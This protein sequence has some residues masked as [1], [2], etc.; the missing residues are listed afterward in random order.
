MQPRL[1]K[2]P[3][4]AVVILAIVLLHLAMP[5]PAA[6][7]ETVIHPR[8]GR[9]LLGDVHPLFVDGECFLFHLRPGDYRSCLLRSRDLLRWTDAEIT[10]APPAPEVVAKAHFVLGVFR[11]G[12]AGTWRSLFGH[13]GRMVASESADLVHWRYGPE[14]IAIPVVPGERRRDPCVVRDEAAGRWACVMTARVPGSPDGRNGA[15]VA[16][17]SDDLREWTDRGVLVRSGA[18]EPECPQAFRL[19]GRWWLLASVHDRAVGGPSVWRGGDAF[20]GFDAAPPAMLD[21]KDLCAAQVAFDGERPVLFG[22]VP[23]V[24]A[25]PANQ[26]WGGD[27]ALPRELFIADDGGLATRLHPRVAAAIRGGVLTAG[28]AATGGDCRL[29]LPAGAPRSSLDA[30]VGASGTD[31]APPRF[32]VTLAGDDG[33]GPAVVVAADRLSIEDALGETWADVTARPARDGARTLR[34]VVDGDIVEA[35]LDGTTSLVARL[36]QESRVRTVVAGPEG[37]TRVGGVRVHTV[38]PGAVGS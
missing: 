37:S 24:A 26:T 34:V 4:G 2:G 36:P 16:A 11:D 3:R 33:T 12:D 30:D 8:P 19:G 10:V 21:G 22:W 9:H 32:R 17:E 14:E 25:R 27:L 29:P 18:G 20:G 6:A 5:R 13:A 28:G 38:R 15:V 31:G 35:F 7:A 23:A 1:P